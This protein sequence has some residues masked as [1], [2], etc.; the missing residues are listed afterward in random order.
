MQLKPTILKMLISLIVLIH[1]G[2][3]VWHGYAHAILEV[4]LPG[5]KTAFVAIVI[6]IVPITGAIL[7]WTRFS[8]TGCC[9]VGISMLGSVLFSVYHHYVLISIDNVEHLPPGATA[10]HA[11]FSNSA[12][13][14]ALSALTGVVLAFYAVGK[15]QH[16]GL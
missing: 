8:S 1:L 14:I 5:F 4:G 6:I 2:G 3:N 16:E 12:E 11:H 13:F 10:A 7:S 9:L 15:L